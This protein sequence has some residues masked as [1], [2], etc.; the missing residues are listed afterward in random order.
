MK[1]IALTLLVVTA[2]GCGKYTPQLQTEHEA[3]SSS[4]VEIETGKQEIETR[5]YTSMDT[6]LIACGVVRVRADGTEKIVPYYNWTYQKRCLKQFKID[7]SQ[8]GA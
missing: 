1:Y 4:T 3:E 5:N 2:V 7:P 8:V 6:I